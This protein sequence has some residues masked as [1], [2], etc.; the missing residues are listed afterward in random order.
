MTNC[1]YSEHTK[2]QKKEIQ[3]QIEE[4]QAKLE[5]L[6]QQK[7]PVEV[8]FKDNYGVYPDELKSNND[9][10]CWVSFKRGYIAA[11]NEVKVEELKEEVK[12]LQEKEWTYKIT[13]EKGET[14]RYKQYLNSKNPT[15]LYECVADWWDDVFTAHSDLNMEASIESLVKRIIEF[16]PDEINEPS[17]C[18]DWDVSWNS[19]YNSYRDILMKKFNGK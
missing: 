3:K 18:D 12:E 7:S 13:D 16:L 17:A 1:N 19:G 9:F 10:S 2:I 11:T 6:E 4:L 8:A 5:E 14:N 15:S